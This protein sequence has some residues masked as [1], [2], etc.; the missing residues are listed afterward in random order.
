MNLDF[1]EYS[2]KNRV[3]LFCSLL[4]LLA[5]G[6]H[7][8]EAVRENTSG[9]FYVGGGAAFFY[10][11]ETSPTQ[12]YRVAYSAP[13]M[14]L[15]LFYRKAGYGF[16][17]AFGIHTLASLRINGRSIDLAERS[18]YYVPLQTSVFIDLLARN[19]AIGTG[20]DLFSF[21]PFY[22]KNKPMPDSAGSDL[23]LA[24]FVQGQRPLTELIDVLA[25]LR[26]GLN[27]TPGTPDLVGINN[28]VAIR[29]SLNLSLL[30]RMP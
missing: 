13:G 18:Q 27:L 14:Q 22:F 25:Q 3:L 29:W 11:M 5:G 20:L 6:I 15:D 21:G 4:A 24:L 23:Y 30:Y 19:L 8:T 12:D 17:G 7:P 26:V 1:I 10:I 28:L 9:Q 2:L 16:A